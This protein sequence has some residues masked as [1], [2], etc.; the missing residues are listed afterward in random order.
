MLG[1]EQVLVGFCGLGLGPSCRDTALPGRYNRVRGRLIPFFHVCG[2]GL[3]FEAPFYPLTDA[4]N[5][6][7]SIGV[8][9]KGPWPSEDRKIAYG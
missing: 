2:S 9:P 3:T 1:I 5:K 6:T 4:G 8:G 7:I